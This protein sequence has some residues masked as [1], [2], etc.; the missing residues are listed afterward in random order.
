[1]KTIFFK[2]I[3]FLFVIFFTGCKQNNE[4]SVT[5]IAS[6]KNQVQYAK[7][8]KIY[9]Y[10]GYSIVTITSPWPEAKENFTYVLQEKNGI[11]P[12]SLKQFSIIPIPIKS[13]VVTSTT[14]IPALEMLG[15]EN[16]LVGFPNT[17]YISSEKTRKRIDSGK[18]REVGTNETL[19]TEVLI[20]MAPDVIV[21]F[22]LNNSNPTLDNLQK[23]G[24]KVMINGDWTEQSPL[25]KAEW[26]K[27]FGA[28]YGLDSKANTI[29]S[30][31]EKE[32]TNTLAL[33]KKA[34]SKPNVLSG[35]MF[36]DQWYVPQG[37]S[38]AALFLKDA[39]SN[40][41]WA[42]TKGTGSLPLP[43][44]KILEI[45][46]DAE[47]WIAPGD[48]SSLKQM[49]ESNPHYSEFASFKNKKVYSYGINKGAKGG[50]LYFEWSPTRPD[51]VLKDLI[52]IFHPELLPNHKLFFFQ[53]LE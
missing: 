18:V 32:Y 48:F 2:F 21:S 27:F 24:L 22:G 23:S 47:Y 51:W 8:L 37:D 5:Q 17:D 15:V 16:T 6:Q 31:I 10:E 42:D 45:A 41:L 13:I 9:K 35:A 25:G 28:L 1:M 20:E 39:H 12:D 4:T 52:T 7:G 50:I 36:Q 30:E 19:N 43:F 29:F 33:A 49:S 26:I 38:W 34:T 40:Y 11:I 3:S 53:K 46:Q 44:E 14:H